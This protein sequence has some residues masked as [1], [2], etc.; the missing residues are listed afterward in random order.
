MK[1]IICDNVFDEMSFKEFEA[2]DLIIFLQQHY[3]KFP[4]HTRIYHNAVAIS[5]DVTPVNE[6]DIEKLSK[7]QGNFFIINYP[8][9]PITV[10]VAVVALIAV[11]AAAFLI[12]HK[13]PNAIA[14]NEINSGNG[15]GSTQSPNNKTLAAR[16]NTDRLNA[17]I[18]DIY[19]KVRSFPD[20]ISLP[21]S[22]FNSEGNEFEIS[23][24]CIGRGDYLIEDIKEGSD[25][26]TVNKFSNYQFYGPNKSP[27]NA[28]PDEEIG[29][30]SN[31]N[32]LVAYSRHSGVNNQTLLAPNITSVP[33]QTGGFVFTTY[34]SQPQHCKILH[35]TI[36][37][38]SIF[39]V[40]DSVIIT[41]TT[42]PSV[43][44]T[45]TVLAFGNETCYNNSI[46]MHNS[47]I[48][49]RINNSFTD[50]ATIT[51]ING[52]GT[53]STYLNISL[54]PDRNLSITKSG[55]INYVGPFNINKS[56]SNKIL[57]NFISPSG[58]Y[59]STGVVVK[60]IITS[61]ATGAQQIVNTTLAVNKYANQRGQSVFITST[62]AAPFTIKFERVTNAFAVAGAG[63][64]NDEVKVRD[65]YYGKNINN[66]H[67]G[68]ITTV[69]AL[70]S[71]SSSDVDRKFN[72]LV[73]R[74]LPARISGS[75][76]TTTLAPTQNAADIISA[77]CLDP[78]FGRRSV[79]E[80]DFDNIYSTVNDVMSYFGLGEVSCG[81]F[82]Y[83][84]DNS[85]LSFEETIASI[86]AAINCTAYRQGYLIKLK[87][88]KETS[89]STLLF[90]HRNI[91]PNTQHRAVNFGI[92]NDHD[93]V[94][95]KY[96]DELTN[97]ENTIYIPNDQTNNPKDIKMIGIRG[98]KQAYYLAW[99]AWN[100]L[101]HQ[102]IA[103]DFEATQE[104]NLL[105]LTDRFLIA[106]QTRNDTQD[107]EIIAQN[108]LTLELS[109]DVTVSPNDIIFIQ[110]TNGVV[111]SRTIVNQI[112]P[113]TITINVAP[114]TPIITNV[115]NYAR[116]TF[117]ISRIG[118][119]VNLPFIL[120]DKQPA[121]KLTN[122]LKAINY[123]PDYYAND[124][125]LVNV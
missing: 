66:L 106:D 8:A 88:E 109:V 101:Q 27:N 78:K 39:S 82:N 123:S 92:T 97:L 61:I 75:N 89:I 12:K 93:G 30:I 94:S 86:A 16:Q 53:T 74:K 90:N 112:N 18:P 98:K 104:S 63:A 102:K 10:V 71:T 77:I 114:D 46:V 13:V 23:Y 58:L 81:H 73:T 2:D 107:G 24:M 26:V 1:I 67:F 40:N 29:S 125:D 99:R 15:S 87:F 120:V 70:T 64:G 51:F 111:S 14:A 47:I 69:Y 41:S 11:A 4:E 83:T 55:S 36:N 91:L 34:R 9:D 76:F 5:N 95:F 44:G 33:S 17:R 52:N 38:I 21:Y 59:Q 56:N 42:N 124:H 3:D 80:V 31:I 68:D 43:N 116:T 7:L 115:D 6:A 122:N 79:N 117:I 32:P 20:L 118:S 72:C 113:N 45:Y 22:Y 119:S 57:V 50:N 85:D 62:I 103:V 105:I 96:V 108:A 48:L 19:G 100:R 35:P 25:S 60:T 37:F 28:K 84:F 121:N 54:L 110:N 65:L 49:S